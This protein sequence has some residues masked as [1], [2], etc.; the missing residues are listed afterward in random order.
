MNCMENKSHVLYIS[1][2]L[3]KNITSMFVNCSTIKPCN[4]CS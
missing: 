1:V 3:D 4:V 2:E